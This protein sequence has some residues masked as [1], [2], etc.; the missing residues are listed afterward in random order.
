MKYFCSFVL[1]EKFEKIS[2]PT[3]F[4]NILNFVTKKNQNRSQNG[5]ASKPRERAWR[6]SRRSKRANEDQQEEVWINI[7]LIFVEFV[8]TFKSE[9][10]EFKKFKIVINLLVRTKIENLQVSKKSI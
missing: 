3:N 2:I 1:F 9:E 7:N 8:S 10:S 5:N 4:K 6:Q